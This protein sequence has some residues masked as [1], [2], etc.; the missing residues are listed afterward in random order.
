LITGEI[1]LMFHLIPG[2]GTQVK[3]QRVRAVAVMSRER[4]P[5]LPEVPT[6]PELG[7]PKMMSSTWFALLAPKG[8]APAVVERMNAV[9]NETLKDPAV[10]KRLND[11]GAA[12]LGGTPKQLADHLA[13]EIEKWGRLV[14]EAKIE[15]Q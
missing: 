8:T 1:A 13:A 3:A 6:M 14:R 2:V 7:A 9:A 15:A 12:T 10:K 4:S 5:A 11:M